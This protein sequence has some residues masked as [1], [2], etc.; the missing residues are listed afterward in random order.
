MSLKDSSVNQLESNTQDSEGEVSNNNRQEVSSTNGDANANR[1]EVD[2]GRTGE[3]EAFSP[4][5][6]QTEEQDKI[7]IWGTDS[8]CDDP[9]LA[10]FEMLECQEL[11]AYLAE[12]EEDFTKV[13][14]AERCPQSKPVSSE[15]RI[16]MSKKEDE[17][18]T[19]QQAFKEPETT[20]QASP[21]KG[22]TRTEVSSETDIFVS[23]FSSVSSLGGSL[24]SALDNA[25]RSQATDSW[26]APSGP[27]RTLSEDLTLASQSCS[28]ISER[29]RGS[30]RNMAPAAKSTTH[31]S[32]LDLNRNSTVLPE[33]PILEAQEKQPGQPSP[34]EEHSG[35]LTNGVSESHQ[36]V[37]DAK[38][39]HIKL[40]DADQSLG[41]QLDNDHQPTDAKTSSSQFQSS[42]L[43]TSD[44]THS[45]EQR[46]AEPKVVPSMKKAITARQVPTATKPSKGDEASDLNVIPPKPIAKSLS[47]HSVSPT[48]L[49]KKQASF[50]RA[51]SAS[52]SSLDKRKPWGSPSRPA[53]PPSPK[54]TWSP[55]R[56]PLSSPARTTSTR[57]PSQERSD[58]P[59]RA[60]SGIKP[61]TKVSISSGIPKPVLPPQPENKPSAKNTSPPQKPKNVRPKIITYVR[62]SPQVK[63]QVTDAPYEVS[64]LPPRLTPYASPPAAK[65]PKATGMK[66]STILSP[67]SMLYDKYKQ[68][69]QKTGYY[70]PGLVVSGIRP[71]SH[72]VPNKLT[73]KSESFHG[74][75]PER[76]MHEVR[77]LI[78]DLSAIAFPI[79]LIVPSELHVS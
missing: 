4:L 6:S 43:V 72:T 44:G 66:T 30:Q 70:G 21:N 18:K 56:R 64:T 39:E 17:A 68:E 34:P 45:L 13:G 79:F 67:S 28:T 3:V 52:P 9:E 60:A 27:Y 65:E 75:L 5:L 58:S 14:V 16:S 10:E 12:E 31:L 2:E 55:K 71:P 69:I 59:Q 22:C 46:P 1:I 26:Q 63:P 20:S 40:T 57:A 61:P 47:C 7:I 48:P 38:W 29:S 53:T 74:E 35:L 36:S 62:K 24:A 54:T 76:Y 78:L 73:G 19:A 8:Q 41:E 49:I 32:G 77:N 42:K 23:C 11:E 15:A 33:E 51:R 37:T 25:G 50:E